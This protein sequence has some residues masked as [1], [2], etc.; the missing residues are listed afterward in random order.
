MAEIYSLVYKPENDDAP[1]HYTRIPLEHARLVEGHGIEGDLK[2]DG[3]PDR[4]LNVMSY[5]TLVAL[6]GEGFKTQPGQMGEQIIVR[7]LNINVLP[8][9]A[10]LQL[11]DSA[12]IEIIKLRTGCDRF[13][14]IQGKPRTDAAGRLG[15]MARVVKGGV[16]AVGAEVKLLEAVEL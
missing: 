13:E 15:V 11:G 2:G 16:V 7:G 5:E 1:D 12:V 3:N 4:Q 10:R 6:G 14:A 8:A 9:G